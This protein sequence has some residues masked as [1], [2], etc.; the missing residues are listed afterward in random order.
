[1]MEPLSKK[2]KLEVGTDTW[3]VSISP[4]QI[5]FQGHHF[6]K[7]NPTTP[8]TDGLRQFM[9][10]LL[11]TVSSTLYLPSC[12]VVIGLKLKKSDRKDI[13][14]STQVGKLAQNFSQEKKYIGQS[15]L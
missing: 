7:V 1:M 3:A 9:F 13:E 14:S 4:T 8:T 6:S 15:F 11:P 2:S 5:S 10:Q 12:E